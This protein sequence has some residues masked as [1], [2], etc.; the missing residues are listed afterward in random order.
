MPP[1][2]RV[3]TTDYQEILNSLTFQSDFEVMADFFCNGGGLLWRKRS[4]IRQD[5]EDG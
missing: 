4:C 2:R 1:Q 5:K 3:R